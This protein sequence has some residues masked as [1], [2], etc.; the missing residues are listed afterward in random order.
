MLLSSQTLEATSGDFSAACA[1]LVEQATPTLI[2]I[3]VVQS[4]L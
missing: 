4:N 2:A 1:A 3:N